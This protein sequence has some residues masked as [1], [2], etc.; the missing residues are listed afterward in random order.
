M[1]P[2][3]FFLPFIPA[4]LGWLLIKI[5]MKLLFKP[6]KPVKILGINFHGFLPRNKEALA[7]YF[8]DEISKELLSANFFSEKFCSPA[9]LEKAMPL[10]ESHIDDFLTHKLAAELPVISMF[11]GEKI[12]NQLKII[13]LKEL[14]EL[15][16]SVMSQFIADWSHSGELKHEMVVKLGSMEIETLEKKFCRKYKKDINK[17][18]FVFAFSGFITG[19]LELIITIIIVQ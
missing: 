4:F 3:L 19:L 18:A 17:V 7:V 10:I 16:P 1:N 8:A 2:A 11:V 14:R 13:F 12:M 9:T 6:L 5:F 15:F